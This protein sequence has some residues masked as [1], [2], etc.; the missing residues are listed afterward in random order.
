[1]PPARAMLAILTLVAACGPKPCAIG[2]HATGPAFLWRVQ[3]A[4]G[5]VV[6]LYGTIHDGGTADVA[7]AAWAALEGSRRFASELGELEPDPDALRDRVRLPRGKGLDQLLPLDDW[8]ELRDALRGVMRE[9]ELARVRPWYAM[10]LL[11]KTVSPPPDP[12][13]DEALTARARAR[14]L[15][16]DPLETWDEQLGE[17]ARTVDIADLAQA[18]EARRTMRC[19]LA[20]DRA[21]YRAG[22]LAAVQRIYGSSA[23]L[24]RHQRWLAA[25]ERYLGGDGAFVAVGI[26]HLVGDGGLPALLERAGYRVERAEPA[27]APAPASTTLR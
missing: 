25:I 14:G 1:M 6:W 2:P 20:R 18:I 12:A 26:G 15:P 22:D 19:D 4:D 24:S 16:I 21:A 23:L 10:S 13:M 5:P 17:L 3:R 27:P 11:T 9:E 8:W 7:P